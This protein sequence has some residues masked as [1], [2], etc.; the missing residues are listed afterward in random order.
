MFRTAIKSPHQLSARLSPLTLFTMSA[1]E[2]EKDIKNLDVA[3]VEQLTA[4]GV[5]SDEVIAKDFGTYIH[6]AA[7]AVHGQKESTI[8]E[9]LKKYRWG[10]LYSIVFSA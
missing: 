2:N 10:V 6:D 4:P 9:A 8:T 3:H 1:F 5:D 7:E